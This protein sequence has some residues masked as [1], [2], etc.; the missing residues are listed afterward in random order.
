MVKLTTFLLHFFI[1]RV[2]FEFN[3]LFIT[4]LRPHSLRFFI[5]S[6]ETFNSYFNS[7][8]RV[9]VVLNVLFFSRPDPNIRG[10]LDYNAI[11]VQFIRV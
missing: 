6:L 9:V 11:N 1:V 7:Y 4:P 10:E 8:W 2:R 5:Y 3:E